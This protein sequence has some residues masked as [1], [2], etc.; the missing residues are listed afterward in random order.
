[1]R[2]DCLAAIAFMITACDSAWA[3]PP[4]VT[5]DPEPVHHRRWEINSAITATWGGGTTSAGIP[6][7]DI[8]YGAVPDIQVHAQPRFSYEKTPDEDHT[9]LDDT[10]VGVKYRFVNLQ[11]EGSTLMVGV[12]PMYM[13]ATGRRALGPDR[14]KHQVFLPLWV[15]RDAQRWTIYGGWG[16]RINRGEGNRNSVFTGATVL[17]SVADGLQFGAEV[18][19]E[20]PDTAGG[21]TLR[22]FNL[23]GIVKLTQ[24]YNVLFSAGK[25]FTDITQRSFYLA[26]QTH[27]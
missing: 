19:H 7:V 21:S 4:F 12:Y 20:T 18:F 2:Y 8:N 24:R 23:G 27:Y 22:G 14:G 16:Y 17:Y 6:S 10:E 13:I 1:M 25:R 9:G 11:G 15:Q 26:L 3:G 5:D